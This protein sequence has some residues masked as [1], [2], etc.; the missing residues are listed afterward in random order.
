MAAQTLVTAILEKKRSKAEG[1]PPGA[2]SGRRLAQSERPTNVSDWSFYSGQPAIPLRHRASLNH[3]MK[4]SYVPVTLDGRVVVPKLTRLSGRLWYYSPETGCI[5]LV[6]R[7][8][9]TM[10]GFGYG[11]HLMIEYGSEHSCAVPAGN[12]GNTPCRALPT[13][14]E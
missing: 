2:V 11:V 7:A 1:I 6:S 4:I 3:T 10:I 8:R 9:E 14:L 12:A 5:H 13:R